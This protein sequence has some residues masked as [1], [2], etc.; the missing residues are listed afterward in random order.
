M[1]RFGPPDLPTV[2]PA[3]APTVP[4]TTLPLVAAAAA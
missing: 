1:A 4:S 3:P 2:A